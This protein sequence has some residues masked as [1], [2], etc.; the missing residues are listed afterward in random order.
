MRFCSNRTHSSK[1]ELQL[2]SKLF[3]AEEAKRGQ[4]DYRFS[5]EAFADNGERIAFQITVY[6][7]ELSA[8]AYNM[9]N[10]TNPGVA[11]SPKAWTVRVDEPPMS[12]LWPEHPLKIPKVENDWDE[13]NLNETED[14]EDQE[15]EDMEQ[16]Q[17]PNEGLSDGL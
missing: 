2:D 14:M 3:F 8:I 12:E 1:Q 13:E 5:S 17:N 4:T 7:K 11:D 6:L 10:K 9:D 15:M 16:E